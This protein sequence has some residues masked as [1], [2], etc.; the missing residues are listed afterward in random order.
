LGRVVRQFV[1]WNSGYFEM[2]VNPIEEWAR[3]TGH[4]FLNLWR[5]AVAASSRVAPVTTGTRVCRRDQH[6]I[7]G[8][9]G[10]PEGSRDGDDTV[11]EWL[12][13]DFE[14][15]AIELWKLIQKQDPIVSFADFTGGW[16]A[17]TTNQSSVA[18]GMVRTSKRTSGHQRLS[19]R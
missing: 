9:G 16:L 6:E 19:I 12:S 18:D 13:H 7:G 14:S 17:S 1:E 8:E 10:G 5:S 3:D 11:F 4:V 15:F 2:N